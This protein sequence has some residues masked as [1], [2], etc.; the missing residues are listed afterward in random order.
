MGYFAS[1][2]IID[3]YTAKFPVVTIGRLGQ[4]ANQAHVSETIKEID[5]SDIIPGIRCPG[6]WMEVGGGI[7]ISDS[8]E[9]PDTDGINE[10]CADVGNEGRP[11]PLCVINK[12]PCVSIS[13]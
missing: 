13:F 2:L 6:A 5:L 7:A 10:Y 8:G 1:I 4:L 9:K 12:G 3:P 11:R